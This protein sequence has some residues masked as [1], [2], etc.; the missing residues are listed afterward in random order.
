[1]EFDQLGFIDQQKPV[2]FS[3]G[4][5]RGP[6]Q[7]EVQSATMREGATLMAAW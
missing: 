7:Q 5:K 1:M 2:C 6:V 4:V 3:V